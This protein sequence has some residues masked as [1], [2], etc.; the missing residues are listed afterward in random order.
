MGRMQMS[1]NFVFPAK[2]GT[3][4]LLTVDLLEQIFPVRIGA[5]DQLNFPSPKPFLN[6]FF[7]S[8]RFFDGRRLL[9][10]NQAREAIASAEF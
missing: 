5:L 6:R 4:L 2:A 8:D 10:K 9:G 7:T 1:P 3:P